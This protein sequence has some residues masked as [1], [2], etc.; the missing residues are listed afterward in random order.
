MRETESKTEA[1]ASQLD[2]RISELFSLQELSYV[3]SESIQLDRIVD[4]VVRYAGRFLQTD[5]IIAGIITIGILG[6]L[7][8]AFFRWLH[9]TLFPYTE[10]VSR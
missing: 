4:Q 7:T 1:L 10:R 8:D 3:L 6:L 5:Q 9:R 2:R